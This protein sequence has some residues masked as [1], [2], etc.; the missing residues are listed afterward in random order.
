MKQ[1]LLVGIRLYWFLKP[2][3]KTPCCIFRKSCSN[4]VF[5]ITEQKGFWKGIRALKFRFKNCR[6]GFKIYRNPKSEQI[7]MILPDKTII[8]EKDIAER[9]L[10]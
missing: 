6:G 4:Y 10:K 3:N 1:F 5:E 2:R 8:N 7:E 9:L